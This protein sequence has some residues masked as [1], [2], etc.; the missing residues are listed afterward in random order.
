VLVDF[1]HLQSVHNLIADFKT[2]EIYFDIVV[3]NAGV[4]LPEEV[5]TVDGIDTTFQ[6]N[7]L[8]QWLLV[9]EIIAFQCP[10]RPLHIVTVRF[11]LYFYLMSN[12]NFILNNYIN[13]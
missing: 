6:V 3:L 12:N 8:A 11:I 13:I 4:L 9:R 7:F 5:E 10:M 2:N 1:A